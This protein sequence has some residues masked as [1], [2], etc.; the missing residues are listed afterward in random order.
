MGDICELCAISQDPYAAAMQGNPQS[1][2]RNY[3]STGNGAG[4]S[5]A[6]PKGRSRKVL[7][8]GNPTVNTDPYGNTIVP[9]AE[10]E[11][12]VQ[13]YHAGQ[14]PLTQQSSSD[15]VDQDGSSAASGAKGGT[16]SKSSE[17][18]TQGITKNIS[19]DTE[20]K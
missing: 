16:A 5:Y 1:V 9:Q 17:P 15:V 2:S 11:D 20:K 8:G 13:V 6:P 7:L 12:K 19:V 10:E 14:V 18:L 4:T 3:S